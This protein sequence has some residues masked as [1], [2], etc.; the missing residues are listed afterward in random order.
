MTFNIYALK[1]SAEA[2]VYDMEGVEGSSI[3]AERKGNEIEISLNHTKPCWIK[4][5]GEQV[6]SVEGAEHTVQNNNTLLI[7]KAEKIKVTLG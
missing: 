1:S 2:V 7:P 6:A 5:I 3:R 4:L